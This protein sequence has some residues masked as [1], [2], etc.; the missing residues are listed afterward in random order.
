MNPSTGPDRQGWGR[1]GDD[2]IM[3]QS[4]GAGK[5]SSQ[6]FA[7]DEC[8]PEAGLPENLSWRN[9]PSTAHHGQQSPQQ[10]QDF[11]PGTHLI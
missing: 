5:H 3:N 4:T 9:L 2:R 6:R 1:M 10:E 7:A 8:S 11:D